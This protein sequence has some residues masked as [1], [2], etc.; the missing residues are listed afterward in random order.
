MHTLSLPTG[1]A[2]AVWQGDQLPGAGEAPVLSSGFAA[3]DA[4]LPGG[5]WPCQGLSE[6]LLPAWGLAE[7]RLTAP[8]L[9]LALQ[10]EGKGKA[11]LFIG[12]PD[13]PHLPGWRAAGLTAASMVWVDAA[14]PQQRL[15]AA[16]QALHCPEVAAVL[17]WLPPGRGQTAGLRR[18]QV[19]S[20][21]GRRPVFVFRPLAAQAESSPAPLRLALQAC[22]PLALVLRLLKRRGPAHERP[23]ELP[24]WPEGLGEGLAH[25]LAARAASPAVPSELSDVFPPLLARPVPRLGLHVVAG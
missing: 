1:V 2:G 19:H 24:A 16:E 13:P 25:K 18:L 11:V 21:Q 17:L 5:G 4:L 7:C 9:S 14:R 23:I 22:R 10:E 15:W 3:L 8:A 20:L 6:I 12:A